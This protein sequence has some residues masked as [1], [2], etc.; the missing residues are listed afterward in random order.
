M[1]AKIDRIDQVTLADGT[2]GFR[3]VDYKTGHA[4]KALLEPGPKDLQLGLYA[5]ALRQEYGEDLAGTAEYWLFSTGERGVL[6]LSAVDEA[7]V[8]KQIDKVVAGI[9]AGD[10]EKGPKCEGQ[11]CDFLG[12]AGRG[13]AG[14]GEA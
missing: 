1:I 14:G 2:A 7:G 6:E 9:L 4:S 3:I 12:P 11:I 13:V 5:L 10:F 8:R